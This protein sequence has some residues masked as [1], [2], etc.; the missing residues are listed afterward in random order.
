MNLTLAPDAAID[1]HMHTTYSDGRWPAQ[2]LIEYLAS[3]HFD[4]VAVTDHNRVDKVAEIQA[5]GAEKHLTILSG[6][7]MSTVW[8]GKMGDLLCYGFDI[9]SN[10]LNS[11]IKNFAQIQQEKMYNI[12]EKLLRKGYTFPKQEKILARS[13]G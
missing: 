6:V 4:L 11:I 3:E 5:L 2:Q 13:G 1:L 12:H 7:E 8:N 9:E 10:E